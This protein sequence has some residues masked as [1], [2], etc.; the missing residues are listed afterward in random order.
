VQGLAPQHLEKLSRALVFP[1]P[2]FRAAMRAGRSTRGIAKFVKYY[3]IPEDST[4]SI[5]VPR[6]MTG[7]VLDTTGFPK[8]KV[9]DFTVAPPA[10]FK[11]T[12][13]LRDYQ[14]KAMPD[15]LSRRYGLVEAATGAGKTI[16]GIGYIAERKLTTLILVHSKELLNQWHDR[17]LEFTNLERVG[18][19][20][21]GKFDVQDVTVG[22]INTVHNHRDEL[23]DLFGVNLYD[24][25]HRAIGDTWVSTINTLRP[26]FHMGFSATPYRSDGLTKA[27]YRIVGPMVHKVDRQYL[28]DSGAV[29]VP[30]IIRTNTKFGYRFKNDY[31]KMI[32]A[33]VRSNPRNVQIANLIIQEHKKYKEPTM[34]VSD[35]VEHCEILKHLLD[36]QA[37]LSPV[38]LTGQTPKQERT[39]VIKEMKAGK[40]NALVATVQLLGEGFDAPDL[41]SLFLCTP[42]KFQGRTLQ[43]IG[44]ILRPSKGGQPRV[45]DFRDV[46]VKVLRNSGFARD[47][48]YRGHGWTT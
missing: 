34:I 15:M 20:G 8:S 45:Y 5:I 32:T 41:N 19:I 11:F 1:N 47:R 24:E 21:D 13:K 33:L 43:T 35:R 37:G 29:Q 30:R 23:K 18:L 16:M 48:V 27:L 9:K 31:A 40:Y 44:R 17:I 36:G 12:G 7:M 38:L 39:D 46:A 42:I 6:G 22:I 3:K 14:A 4:N 26:R 2:K 25:V 28:E 10:D